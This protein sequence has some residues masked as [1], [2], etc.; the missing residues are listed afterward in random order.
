MNSSVP[1]TRNRGPV[2]LFVGLWA[3]LSLTIALAEGAPTPVQGPTAGSGAMDLTA[4]FADAA[5]SAAGVRIS[6]I[7]WSTDEERDRLVAAMNPPPRVAA[8]E[9]PTQGQRGGGGGR[10]GRGGRGDA[11]AE[12]EDPVATALGEA[13]TL[14][15]IWTESVAGYSIKYS[16]RD[17][18]ADGSE[19]IILATQRRLARRTPSDDEFTL[20]EIRLD[21][22]GS[23]EA[24]M[25]RLTQATSDNATGRIALDNYAAT[26][27][28]LQN[29]RR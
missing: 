9:V 2:L 8:P 23:G 5:E 6:I 22:G 7:R 26:P 1:I 28:V 21:A 17:T 14:G 29:V 12:P 15:Y 3:V 4:S 24:R 10:G 19:Q 13:Q 25:S 11:P 16:Y 27:A 20:I 18:L